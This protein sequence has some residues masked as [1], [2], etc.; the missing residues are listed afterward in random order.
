MNTILSKQFIKYCLAV[1]GGIFLSL[2][3][4]IHFLQFWQRTLPIK[5]LLIF[6][7]SAII[8]LVIFFVFKLTQKLNESW[9]KHLVGNSAFIST[10]LFFGFMSL[11]PR[12]PMPERLLVIKVDDVPRG[13]KIILSKVSISEVDVPL[14][15]LTRSGK[16]QSRQLYGAKKQLWTESPGDLRLNFETEPQQYFAI[17][18]MSNPTGGK[19]TVKFDNLEQEVDLFS[20][21]PIEKKVTGT[22]YHGEFWLGI[23]L[24]DLIACNILVILIYA[25]FQ[26]FAVHLLKSK[27]VVLLLK[28]NFGKFILLITG[29]L[30]F[31]LIPVSFDVIP[32]GLAFL[33]SIILT[34]TIGFTLPNKSPLKK[35]LNQKYL[36][37]IL[38]IAIIALAAI[39]LIGWY[40]RYVHDD[41]LSAI[42]LRNGP[43]HLIKHMYFRLFGRFSYILVMSHAYLFSPYYARI[44]P[45]VSLLLFWFLTAKV[46][47]NIFHKLGEQTSFVHSGIIASV[48]CGAFLF[49]TPN[50]VQSYYWMVGNLLYFTPYIF[51]L[52]NIYLFIKL[53]IYR[54]PIFLVLLF[55]ASFFLGG[56]TE[57][58][59]IALIVIAVSTSILFYN[60]IKNN[61]SIRVPYLIMGIGWISGSCVSLLS[62]GVI[63][64][65]R[66][67]STVAFDILPIINRII[68]VPIKYISDR[69]QFSPLIFAF[70]LMIFFLLGK[71]YLSRLTISTTIKIMAILAATFWSTFAIS[72]LIGDL[73]SRAYTTSTLFLMLLVASFGVVL[74]RISGFQLDNID[75]QLALSYLLIISLFGSAFWEKYIFSRDQ[76]WNFANTWDVTHREFLSQQEEG[77]DVARVSINPTLSFDLGEMGSMYSTENDYLRYYGFS[78]IEFPGE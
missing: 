54:N 2:S 57:P 19:V 55:I 62:P 78:D 21:S 70:L 24:V 66:H 74:S 75:S 46:T 9:K 69:I 8:S 23:I 42:D 20:A 30:S 58:L 40:S 76:L 37:I 16:W 4:S 36:L 48:F 38:F 6:C 7:Q 68:S 71:K 67:N 65:L 11:N 56:F 17:K 64:R 10:I 32:L 5:C 15:N 12:I 22:L 53:T 59:A 61:S 63:N 27:V 13:E 28:H 47:Q 3:I 29:I 43:W 51:L 45:G 60:L 39:P 14:Y 49:L 35:T 50:L 72:A 31:L 77:L 44:L 52:G 41:Y 25:L 73:P 1:I 33:L 18:F 34:I 26:S